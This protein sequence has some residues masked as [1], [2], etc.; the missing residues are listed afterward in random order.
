[1]ASYL[2]N[3][4]RDNISLYTIP[5]AW[6]VA[7]M[8]RFYA[9]STYTAATNKSNKPIAL[10][11]RDFSKIA[12]DEQGLDNKTRQRIIRAEAAQA[13]GF[14]N[15]GLFAAAVAAGN[16]AGLEASTLNGVAIA[17]IVSRVVYNH[18]YIYNDLLPSQARTATFFVGVGCC[19]A[20]FVQAGNKTKRTLL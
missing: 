14:E 3:L 12:A 5:I 9:L 18:V 11:P 1:M 7:I 10:Q 13:N 4:A 2:P 20:L 15:L 6:I 19:M 8:P 17:Y 16:A